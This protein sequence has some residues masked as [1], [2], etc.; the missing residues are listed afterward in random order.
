M[1]LVVDMSWASE[2]VGTLTNARAEAD[3]YVQDYQKAKNDEYNLA[4]SKNEHAN[5][6][7]IVRLSQST[8][9][10]IQSIDQA[11]TINKGTVIDK[12]LETIQIVDVKPHPNLAD[13]DARANN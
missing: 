11:Y 9:Q 5:S 1:A 2:R 8:D 7:A 13:F 6:D 12:L 10:A 3:K 4:L